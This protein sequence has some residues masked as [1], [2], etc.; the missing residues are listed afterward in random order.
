MNHEYNPKDLLIE[1]DRER[2]VL[3]ECDGLNNHFHHKYER[4][5]ME[6]LYQVDE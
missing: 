4:I 3:Q 1:V 5:D 6:V 2:R